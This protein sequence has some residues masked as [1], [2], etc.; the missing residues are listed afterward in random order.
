[1]LDFGGQLAH[2]SLR[3]GFKLRALLSLGSEPV[4]DFDQVTLEVRPRRKSGR[5]ALPFSRR[6]GPQRIFATNA[7]GHLSV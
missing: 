2:G 5:K 6:L 3:L 7:V 4:F 1:M